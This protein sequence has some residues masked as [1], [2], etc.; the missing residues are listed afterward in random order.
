[1]SPIVLAFLGDAV[2]SLYIREKLAFSS[3]MKSGG[4]HKLSA[5]S[6]N[7]VSQSE[8]ALKLLPY[9]SEEELNIYKRAR[10]TKKG[11]KSKSSSVADYNRSTGFEALIGFLYIT[12]NYERL[13]Y[14][15]NI[16]VAENEN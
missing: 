11:T 16:E 7:A 2:Y 12:G 5:A 9:L 3:D 10:N 4:L 6:V 13:N 15:L 14:L 1:M 8:F